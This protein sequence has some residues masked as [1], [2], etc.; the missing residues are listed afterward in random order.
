MTYDWLF[1][2]SHGDTGSRRGSKNNLR[3]IRMGIGPVRGI[4]SLSPLSS[5]VEIQSINRY[6]TEHRD[7]SMENARVRF[8]FTS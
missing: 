3:G 2:N 4:N 7:Y 8:L 5:P 1:R 6:Q